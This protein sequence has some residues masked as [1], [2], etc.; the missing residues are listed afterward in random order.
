MHFENRYQ[1]VYIFE[2]DFQIESNSKYCKMQMNYLLEI[3]CKILE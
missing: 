3:L 1:N 2:E